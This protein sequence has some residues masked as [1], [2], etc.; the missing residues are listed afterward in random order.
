[1]LLSSLYLY[2]VSVHTSTHK[3][4]CLSLGI[5]H[6]TLAKS[7]RKTIMCTNATWAL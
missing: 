6:C 5:Y 3:I 4:V 1:M 7:A 2:M